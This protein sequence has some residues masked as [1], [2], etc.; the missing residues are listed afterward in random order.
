MIKSTICH[1]LVIQQSNSDKHPSVKCHSVERHSAECHSAECHS[2][3]WNHP[4]KCRSEEHHSVA[5]HFADC[6]ST[7]FH[8]AYVTPTE[9]VENVLPPRKWCYVMLSTNLPFEID[10]IDQLVYLIY[11]ISADIFICLIDLNFK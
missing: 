4:T 3:E 9:N 1:Y 11:L 5:C 8:G 10:E 2:A 7:K 6:R